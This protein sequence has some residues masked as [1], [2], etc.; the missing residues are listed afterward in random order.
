MNISLFFLTVHFA[1]QCL[2]KSAAKHKAG[3]KNEKKAH[4]KKRCVEVV[5]EEVEE[6]EEGER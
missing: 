5:E 4:Q 3:D 2:G 1:K 6:E